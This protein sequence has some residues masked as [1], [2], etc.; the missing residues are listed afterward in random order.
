LCSSRH[1]TVIPDGVSSTYAVPDLSAAEIHLYMYGLGEIF[2]YPTLQT[3]AH[4]K[5][6]EHLVLNTSYKLTPTPAILKSLVD[7]LYADVDDA[8]RI[9]EDA[10]HALQGTLV[11]S[12]ITL[13]LKWW[14]EEQRNEWDVLIKNDEAFKRDCEVVQEQNKELFEKYERTSKERKETRQERAE[15]RAERRA[16]RKAERRAGRPELGAQQRLMR[17][18]RRADRKV[19]YR[20]Q[21]LA[22]RGKMGRDGKEKAHMEASGGDTN[23]MSKDVKATGEDIGA[24]EEAIK[25][26]EKGVASMELD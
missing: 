16:E 8:R 5:L 6:I 24:V 15:I 25:A 20:A 19:T 18:A 13:K 1:A 10:D 17:Q 23:A 3:I 22:I 11:V 4:G 21:A 9:C 12:A 7:I 2:R 14:T 26:V